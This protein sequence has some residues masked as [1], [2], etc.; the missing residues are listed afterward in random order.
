[1]QSDSLDRNLGGSRES[2]GVLHPTTPKT[3]SRP[4]GYEDGDVRREVAAIFAEA[5]GLGGKPFVN[6]VLHGEHRGDRVPN[7]HFGHT[8]E[9]AAKPSHRLIRARQEAPDKYAS[10]RGQPGNRQSS[11]GRT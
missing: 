8:G 4:A 3:E 10:D 11:E 5:Q 9:H 7:G 1:M 6:V 2:N